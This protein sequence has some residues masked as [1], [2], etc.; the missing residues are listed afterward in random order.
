MKKYIYPVIGAVVGMLLAILVVGGNEQERNILNVQ[1]SKTMFFKYSL[2][3]CESKVTEIKEKSGV[4]VTE[5]DVALLQRLT[6]EGNSFKGSC[7]G[8]LGDLLNSDYAENAEFEGY[9]KGT[10]N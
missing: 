7:Y 8:W 1:A 10:S 4:D 6:K 9:L 5:G 2:S 3:L